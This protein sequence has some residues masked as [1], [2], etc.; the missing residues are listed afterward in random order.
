MGRSLALRTASRSLIKALATGR[1]PLLKTLVDNTT[2]P[3]ELSHEV[4]DLGD[5]ALTSL[6][7]DIGVGV[8]GP[9]HG[10]DGLCLAGE[11]E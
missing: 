11:W 9:A 5:A 3:L 2:A 4:A 6:S 10:I 8:S 7:H 1:S